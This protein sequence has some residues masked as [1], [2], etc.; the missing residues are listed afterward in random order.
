MSG[1]AVLG[2]GVDRQRTADSG[3][4]TFSDDEDEGPA[5]EELE[6]GFALYI[7]HIVTVNYSH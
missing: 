1:S 5:A 6:V 3:R 7:E 4:T 2:A